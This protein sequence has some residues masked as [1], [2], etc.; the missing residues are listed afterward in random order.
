M[1][2]DTMDPA[3]ESATMRILADNHARLLHMFQ[4][5]HEELALTKKS[6]TK[7]HNDHEISINRIAEMDREISRMLDAKQKADS[8]RN[9]IA[10]ESKRALA[11]SEER[12]NR[13]LAELTV[14]KQQFHTSME[15]QAKS[16]QQMENEMMQ[17]TA[18]LENER[19]KVMALNDEKRQQQ[20]TIYALKDKIQAFERQTGQTS[21]HAGG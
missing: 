8:E 5:D 11:E 4:E 13:A 10:T 9:A 1:K 19:R 18:Q 16:R 20:F 7:L 21:D 2:F 6:L 3:E 15:R 14:V 17:L 12:R